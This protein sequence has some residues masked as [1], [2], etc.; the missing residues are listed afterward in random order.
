MA[1]CFMTGIEIQL[2]TACLLDCGAA[3]RA[4]LNLKQKL[5]ALERLVSQLTPKDTVEVLNRRTG[6][7]KTHAQRRLVAPTVAAALSS[8]Y[9]DNHLFVTWQE[10]TTRRPPVFPELRKPAKEPKVT[11]SVAS[12]AG[13]PGL[14]NGDANG[15]HPGS[16]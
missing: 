2:D 14:S 9:P 11:A 10:L 13:G 5:A 7:T 3:K 12:T 6:I 16:A 4:V 8:A 1:K 15:H